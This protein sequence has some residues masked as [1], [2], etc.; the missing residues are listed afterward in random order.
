MSPWNSTPPVVWPGV[1]DSVPTIFKSCLTEPAFSMTDTTFCIWRATEENYWKTGTISFPEGDDPDGSAWMLAILD[2]SPV[3]YKEWAED[4]YDLPINLEAIEQVYRG[5]ILTRELVEELNN[6]AD[7][8]D[9]LA[10]A[11]EIDYPVD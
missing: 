8:S 6:A 3:T 1:L 5:A 2:G 9:I 10:D 7:F 4:Y 11:A